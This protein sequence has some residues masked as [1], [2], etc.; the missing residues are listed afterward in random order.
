MEDMAQDGKVT[1]KGVH[2]LERVHMNFRKSEESPTVGV[3]GLEL[4][5]KSTYT[6]V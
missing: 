6:I 5:H 4:N 1:G 2:K 3:W